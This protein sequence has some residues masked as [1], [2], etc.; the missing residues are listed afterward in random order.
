MCKILLDF[1]I[2]QPP[3]LVG[4]RHAVIST[5]IDSGQRELHI[6]IAE[7]EQRIAFGIAVHRQIAVTQT[8]IIAE[9]GIMEIQIVFSSQLQCSAPALQPA[10]A[11]SD[12]GI[13]ENGPGDI[14]IVAIGCETCSHVPVPNGGFVFP[15][16]IETAT[17]IV[18]SRVKTVRLVAP[19]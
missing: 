19:E 11:G 4:Q 3:D 8:A 17:E 6:A 12:L 9:A 1:Q 10:F 2:D 5:R 15:L 16:C 13:G 14:C 18:S 7:R